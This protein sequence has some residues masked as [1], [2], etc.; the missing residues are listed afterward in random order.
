[1]AVH[2]VGDAT[3]ESE[4]LGAELPVFVDLWAPWCGP[5]RA[6]AP[7]VERLSEAYAGRMKFVKVN[8]DENPAVAQAFQVQSIPM[9]AMMKGD[10]VLDVTLGALP[11]AQLAKWID[12]GLEA[13][14]QGL[15]EQ[16]AP[17]TG[18]PTPPVGGRES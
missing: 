12:A 4:V 2:E 13:V 16:A 9:L 8:V 15:H 1:M 3:F 17:P 11:E 18:S 10:A 5:C 14:R 6:V 7:I